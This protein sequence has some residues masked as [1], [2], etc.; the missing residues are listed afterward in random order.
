MKFG[1]LPISHHAVLLGEVSYFSLAGNDAEERE[2]LQRAL[3]LTA[4]G[5]RVS[6][7]RGEAEFES[8]MRMLDSLGY[9][10]GYTY[11]H[12]VVKEMPRSR[13]A[14]EIPATTSSRGRD[15]ETGL[16]WRPREGLHRQQRE[17][18]LWLTSPNNYLKTSHTTWRRVE[19]TSSC[20]GT[21]NHFVPLN[22]HPSEVLQL[23][24]RIR[25]QHWVEIMTAGPQSQRLAG[26]P[27][28]QKPGPA[29]IYDDESD[30]LLPPNP[31]SQ[32]DADLEEYRSLVEQHQSQQDEDDATEVEE[33]STFD[34]STLSLSL[35]PLNSPVKEEAMPPLADFEED[36]SESIT[37][38]SV[39]MEL[40]V[41]I[42]K[43]TPLESNPV[44][45]ATAP[46]NTQ[47]TM[48][49]T[50]PSSHI[51]VATA[52]PSNQSKHPKRRRK[53]CTPSLFR[54]NR[55]HQTDG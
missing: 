22:T 16:P 8:L 44:T 36:L 2:E 26:V 25:E 48:A 39:N 11:R 15:K 33:M 49:T 29:Y 31:F 19:G 46:P 4:K 21:P 3:G 52:A 35:S 17:R 54:R 12:P 23:R 7:R 28:D 9:Q 13:S 34:G 27:P 32:S 18:A 20:R 53:L 51:T 1:L 40:E 5:G 41:T 24:N 38:L 6:W 42:V 43:E 14:V 50:A 47:I 10:T 45:T 55:R 30:E 37:N